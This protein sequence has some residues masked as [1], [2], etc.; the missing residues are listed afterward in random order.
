MNDTYGDGWNGNE[1]DLSF[2]GGDSTYTFSSGYQATYSLTV[3]YLDTVEFIWQAGG[4]YTSECSFR[5]LDA[6]G[7]AVYSS[8]QGNLMTAGSTQYYLYCNTIA[9]C[10]SPSNVTVTTGTTDAALSWT[11]NASSYS[12]TLVEY[13][14]VGFVQGTG[15]TDTIWA[16]GDTAYF[17]GL[18]PATQYDFKVTTI[19]SS[20]DS[21]QTMGVSGVY[22]QCA[23]LAT[24]L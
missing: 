24:L 19:C 2:T 23:A 17:D 22:T 21:S 3:P 20:T 4:S 15:A 12:Y 14:P 1:L 13:G 18:N 7:T 5:I 11:T 16:Y 9:S 6:S 10:A 8:S